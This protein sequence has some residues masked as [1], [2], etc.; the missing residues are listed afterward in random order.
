MSLPTMILNVEIL[1][2]AAFCALGVAGQSAS[3][4]GSNVRS[5]PSFEGEI[6]PRHRTA[7]SARASPKR[8]S[9]VTSEDDVRTVM[10]VQFCTLMQPSPGP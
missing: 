2:V 9:E 4:P 8:P 5:V 10:P 6:I 1:A 7:S 3:S